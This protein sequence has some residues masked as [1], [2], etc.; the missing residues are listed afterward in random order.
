M[1][2]EENEK[3]P[4]CPICLEILTT[5]LNFASHGYLYQKNCF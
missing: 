3:N 4:I 2:E 1:I 5:K